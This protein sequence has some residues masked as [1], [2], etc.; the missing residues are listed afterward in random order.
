MRLVT[1]TKAVISRGM[2]AP[3]AKLAAD[4]NAGLNRARPRR[5]RNA[6]FIASMSRQGVVCHQLLGNL[7][8]QRRSKAT[9]DID[10]CQLFVLARVVDS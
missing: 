10:G 9:G 7:L 2:A 6:Q 1:G 3:A 5:I 8:S 4:A